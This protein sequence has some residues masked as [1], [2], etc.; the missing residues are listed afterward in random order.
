MKTT[1]SWKA[2]A[3]LV[4]HALLAGSFGDI[5][6]GLAEV[7]RIDQ[8][9][10]LALDTDWPRL[11]DSCMNDA[12][13]FALMH[14]GHRVEARLEEALAGVKL[15]GA[16]HAALSVLVTQ[17]QPI[18]LSEL[19]EKLTCVRSNVTQLV[20]RLEADGLVKRID[21]PADRRAVRAEVTRLGRERHAAGTRVVNAVLED[22]AKELSAVDSQVLKRALDAVR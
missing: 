10:R 7:D 5:F 6:R 19:A 18:S 20:D 15:S 2:F 4:L 14:A 9:H 1:R 3:G 21:D 8:R 22:V 13:A 16:K 17:D 11:Y 12:I